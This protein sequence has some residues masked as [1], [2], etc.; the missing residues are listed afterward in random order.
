MLN[1]YAVGIV[2]SGQTGSSGRDFCTNGGGSSWNAEVEN[3][4]VP[5]NLDVAIPISIS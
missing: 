1:Y 3:A 4:I 2:N 5:A